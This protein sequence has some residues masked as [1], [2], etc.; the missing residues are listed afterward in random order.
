VNLDLPGG[1]QER[2]GDQDDQPT[3]KDDPMHDEKRRQVHLGEEA[4]QIKGAREACEDQR[5]GKYGYE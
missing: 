3:G 2:L 4:I 1:N 5:R